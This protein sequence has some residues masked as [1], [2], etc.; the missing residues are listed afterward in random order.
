MQDLHVDTHALCTLTVQVL[1]NQSKGNDTKREQAHEERLAR[2][3][4]VELFLVPLFLKLELIHSL[5]WILC[6][7]GM[8]KLCIYTG[9]ADLAVDLGFFHLG[10]A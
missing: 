4:L 8:C 10:S 7:M 1:P 6:A 5:I 9:S 2:V 3:K